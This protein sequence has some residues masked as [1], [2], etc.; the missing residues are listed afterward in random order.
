LWKPAISGAVC[1]STDDA[2]P[3]DHDR[4]RDHERYGRVELLDAGRLDEDEG[5]EDA[6]RGE[7]IGAQ[8]R[9]VAL[10]RR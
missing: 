4:P 2:Q 1:P 9:G 3:R 5:P 6:D 10:E 8:M 7:R